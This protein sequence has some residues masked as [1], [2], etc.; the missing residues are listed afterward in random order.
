MS[1]HAISALPMNFGH[2]IGNF[3]ASVHNILAS[4]GRAQ[5]AQHTYQTLNSMTDSEL[6]RRG[7]S[8]DAIP[9]IIQRILTA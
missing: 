5:A 4:F 7:M 3:F 1:A 6:A 2:G 9:A 8:R